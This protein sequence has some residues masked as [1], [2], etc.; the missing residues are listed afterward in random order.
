[1]KPL[2]LSHFTATSCIGHGLEQ[3][4]D[5]LRHG[6]QALKPCDFE[7]VD[8]PTFIGEVEGVD[9]VKM[10]AG[11]ADYNCRNNRLAQL[12]LEQDGFADAVNTA[13]DKYGRD[14]IGVFMGTSTSGIL[15]TELAFR[16]R[17]S[18]TGALP[19]GLIYSKTQ[20]TYSVADFTRQYFELSGPAAAVSSACS[21]S[22]KVFSTARRMI[23]AGLIDAAVVGGVDTLC[24]TTLY[25]FTSLGLLSTQACRPY[26]TERDGISI[27]EAAAFA[28]LERPS[29]SLSTNQDAR[30]VLLLG[31]G[32]SSDAY[33][34]SSPHPEGLGARRAM[35]QA[36]Q[37]AG[38]SPTEIDYINL[39]GTA[40]PSND[41]A[42]A[43]GVAAVF[44][45]D[46]PCSSTK[47]AT[48]HALGAAGAVEAVICALALQH[49]FIPGGLNTREADSLLQLNYQLQNRDQALTRVMSNS[50]GFGGTNCSLIFG[51]AQD[52]L[53]QSGGPK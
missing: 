42:E 35:Q 27:G 9:D 2:L 40:T 19:V 51:L 14:R 1:M 38:L 3:T 24:L 49:G 23:E 15:E 10:A 28:L 17:D 26:D 16:E 4:L 5:A 12:G 21:S 11:M 53:E 47:G 29:P 39:H 50:F 46:T 18:L 37:S 22:A 44:G 48:G 41:A 7:T 52:D 20:N 33:H 36:L 43:K 25:G 30:A 6:R 34:M 32:E 13:A 45:H 8:L 31:I